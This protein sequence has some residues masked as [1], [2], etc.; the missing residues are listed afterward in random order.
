MQKQTCLDHEFCESFVTL[1]LSRKIGTG[2]GKK[3]KMPPCPPAIRYLADGQASESKRVRHED[4]KI[5]KDVNFIN[6]LG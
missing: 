2:S 1:C 5:H 3:K 6:F 4:S